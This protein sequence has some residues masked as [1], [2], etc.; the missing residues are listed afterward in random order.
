MARRGAP[1]GLAFLLL[2]FAV[3][4]GQAQKTTEVSLRIP[5][6]LMLSSDQA[7]VGPNGTEL[8]VAV[9]I[10]KPTSLE[11]LQGYLHFEEFLHL[12]VRSNV[13]WALWARVS[14]VDPSGVLLYKAPEPRVAVGRQY[15]PLAHGAPGKHELVLWLTVKADELPLV[16]LLEF[17]LSVSLKAVAR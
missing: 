14:N 6:L 1:I 5:P 4:G 16:L 2:G 9:S 17:R 12:I 11:H 15:V 8:L 13:P 3:F 10:R 7:A